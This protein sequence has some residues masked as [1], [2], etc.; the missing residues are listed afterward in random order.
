MQ[1]ETKEKTSEKIDEKAREKIN[2]VDAA[3]NR[4]GSMERMAVH[5]A[6]ALHEAFSIF[7]MNSRGEMMLQKRSRRKYHSAGLWSNACCGH[8]RPGESVESAASRRLMEEM[9]VDCELRKL[10]EFVYRVDFN[11]GLTEHEYDHVLVGIFDGEPILNSEEV[12]ETRWIEPD[13]LRQEIDSHSEQYTY[14]F[15]ASV[16]KVF[17]HLKDV[18]GQP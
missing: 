9:G 6:G 4:V 18:D 5:R 17:R 8:P 12:E 2:L 3:G 11:N 7:I 14:W 1:G 15:K 10:F 13:A 16:D